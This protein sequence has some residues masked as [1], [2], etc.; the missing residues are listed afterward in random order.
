MSD[1]S[2]VDDDPDALQEQIME[3]GEEVFSHQYDSDHPGGG[4]FVAIHRLADKYA[5]SSDEE[6]GGPF[7]SF[8]EAL[9]QS[10]GLQ[11]TECSFSIKCSMLSAR[12]IAERLESCADEDLSLWI[13]G[14]EWAHRGGKFKKGKRKK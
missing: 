4:G 10:G 7:D 3:E 9:E 11:V 14:E 6:A 12:Q 1:E 13:N 5:F 2:T 8:E